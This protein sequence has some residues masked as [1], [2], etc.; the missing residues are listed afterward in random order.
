[1]T[2]TMDD[3][4]KVDLRV[5]EILDAQAVEGADKLLKL[6]VDLGTERRTAV[7]GL[8]PYYQPDELR[9]VKTVVVTNL[10]P[11]RLRGVLSEC[12]VL[13]GVTEGFAQ[14]SVVKVDPDIPN[15]AKVM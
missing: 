10:Q 9:G 14:V 2:I 5:G 12:M 6:T 3:F 4:K 15:G 1:M 8:A 13:A 7:A 11:A